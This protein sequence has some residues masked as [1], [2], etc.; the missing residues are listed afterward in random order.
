[1]AQR[2]VK[3]RK[4]AVRT[5]YF[6]YLVIRT[7]DH[8]VCLRK[9]EGNDIWKNL[10][11]F[12]CIESDTPLELEAVVASEAFQTLIGTQAFTIGHPSRS[13][14]H[15]LTHQTLMA[16]FFEIKINSFLSSIQTNHLLLAPE[17]ELGSFPV[18]KL[19]ENYLRN[20]LN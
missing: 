19:I 16:V 15:K 9:R 5:R 3:E 4:T 18:P 1:M 11:D 8:K 6:H 10:Y 20:N 12:P 7:P 17:N 2:P 14:T 13:F